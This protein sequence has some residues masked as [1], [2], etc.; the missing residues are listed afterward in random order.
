MSQSRPV[1]LRGAPVTTGLCYFLR[2]LIQLRWL[3]AGATAAT[4]FV[5]QQWI[6][7]S[8]PYPLLYL[9]AAFIALYNLGFYL[10]VHKN[11]PLDP[12]SLE[13]AVDQQRN[14]A[15]RNVGLLQINLDL[16]ALFSLL[17]FSG[18]LENPCVLFFIF[19]VVIAGIL[20]SPR[21]ALAE[22][23][24]ASFPKEILSGLDLTHA[25]LFVLG[26]PTMLSLTMLGLSLFTILIMR[27]RRRRSVEIVCL[28]QDLVTKN[29]QLLR[30]DEGRRGLLA[31]ASHDLK[32]PIAAVAGYLM[33]LRGGYIGEIN[34]RQG[35]VLDKCL[36]RLDG[37]K[38]FVSDVLSWTAIESGQLRMEMRRIDL[39][40]LLEQVVEHYRDRA[41][42]KGISLE[43]EGIEALPEV[44][45]TPERMVQV[46]ENLISN[47]VKYTEKG[48]VVVIAEVRPQVL[49]IIVRDTGIG[50]SAT[51][52]E[53]LFEGFFRAKKVRKKIEGTGLGLSLVK[54]LVEAHQGTI[55]VESQEGHG[56]SF[57]VELPRAG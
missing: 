18:G 11:C 57:I 10:Y 46:F 50:L 26:L 41:K 40:P 29:E 45:A 42:S 7:T 9:N 20:L 14:R 36:T 31:V 1:M 38:N 48:G 30:A 17:H 47:A 25:W 2:L 22:A 49:R 5:F 53:R 33:T 39:M 16:I 37:L 44:E 32:S 34:D 55:W 15:F 27:E 28:S 4:I 56:S 23:V 12:P 51:E 19:H 24:F 3:A 6:G 54:G 8:F 13:T 43:L 35:E 52:Q 21:W